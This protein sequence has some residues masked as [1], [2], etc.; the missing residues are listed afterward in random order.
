VERFLQMSD[1]FSNINI[2]DE[3][4]CKENEDA[5]AGNDDKPFQN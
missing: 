3:C 2:D 5:A 4:C 1:E